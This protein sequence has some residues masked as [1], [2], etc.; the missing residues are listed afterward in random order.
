MSK[1]RARRL[2][3]IF[4]KSFIVFSRNVPRVNQDFF[5]SLLQVVRVDKH[6]RYLGL[7]MDVSYLKMEA[8]GFL[9]EKVKKRLQGWREK[10]L[11]AAGK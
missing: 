7:P 4:E 6:E 9:K 10:T 3:L 11:S 8:F 5:A 1:C 2:I